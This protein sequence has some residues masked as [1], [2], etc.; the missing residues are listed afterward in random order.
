MACHLISLQ[1]PGPSFVN[2]VLH[3]TEPNSSSKAPSSRSLRDKKVKLLTCSRWVL[4]L[5]WEDYLFV[6]SNKPRGVCIPEINVIYEISRTR[7]WASSWGRCLT[8]KVT[9]WRQTSGWKKHWTDSG[10][11]WGRPG[12]RLRGASTRPR[13]FL[14]LQSAKLYS[15]SQHTLFFLLCIYPP[16]GRWRTGGW[17]GWRR[18]TSCWS[19]R[20]SCS[21]N[22]LRPKRN[23]RGQL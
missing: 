14:N 4:V 15:Q 11:S 23:C 16:L 21:R 2:T 12:P 19:E 17:S 3:L 5:A 18:S 22:T 6:K 7:N 8:Q 1:N 20:L 9:W 13:G 10:R